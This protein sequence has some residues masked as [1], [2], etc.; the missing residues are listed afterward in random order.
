MSRDLDV[1]SLGNDGGT[2]TPSNEGHHSTERNLAGAEIR[3]QDHLHH[4]PDDVPTERTRFKESARRRQVPRWRHRAHQGEAQRV[5]IPADS[6]HS[7]DRARVLRLQMNL[8]PHSK[9]DALPHRSPVTRI[10][11]DVLKRSANLNEDARITHRKGRPLNCQ[12]SRSSAQFVGGAEW[13]LGGSPD[14]LV[15]WST[16]RDADSPPHFRPCRASCAWMPK[17]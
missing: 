10:S 13:D 2:T 8:K 5:R 1:T 17:R 9:C 6:V 15:P 11:A 16:C 14:M 7:L 3:T 4:R 12:T